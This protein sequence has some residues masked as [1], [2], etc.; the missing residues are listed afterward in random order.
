MLAP[1]NRQ[2]GQV[3]GQFG[4]PVLGALLLAIAISPK[5]PAQPGGKGPAA[6]P[7]PASI[8]QQ[9]LQERNA[10]AAQVNKFRAE[11]KWKEAIAFVNKIL[12][13][14]REVFGEN[15]E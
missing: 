12:A 7:L 13:I 9:R 6:P 15:H 1:W 14:E 4:K 10:Y 3:P 2:Q 11:G 8:R 5:C